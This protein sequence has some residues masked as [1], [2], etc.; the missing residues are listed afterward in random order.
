MSSNLHNE[1]EI[2]MD[3]HDVII[4]GA[5]FTGLT[6]GLALARAGCRVMILEKDSTPGGLAG[7][8]EFRNGVRAEKFYHYWYNNDAY[9]HALV[10]E[11]GME[12]HLVTMPSRTGMFYGGQF[13]QLTTPLDLLR[14]S[15][16]SFVDRLRLGLLVFKARRVKEWKSIEHLS[17]REWLKPLCGPEVYKVVWEPLIRSKFSIYADEIGAAWFWK[18][19]VLRGGTRDKKGGE[20]L[21]YFKGGFGRLADALADEIQKAGGAIHY[22]CP[23]TGVRVDNE[24][25]KVVTTPYG[26]V[27]GRQFL[28]TTSFPVIAGIFDGK[29]DEKWLR[30]LRRVRYLGNICLVLQLDRKLSNIFWLNVNDPDFPFVGVIEHTNFDGP[31][32]YAGSHIVY[33]SR[34]LSTQDP[35]WT[36]S[37]DAYLDLAFKHLERMYPGIDRSWIRDYKV[38]RADYAQPVTERNYSGYVPGRRTPYDNAWISTMA[39]VYPEDR[40]TNYSIREGYAVADIIAKDLNRQEL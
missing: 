30:Q 25:V 29:A 31:E 37:D 9:V 13:W 11:V 35:I 39:H 33:L 4:A 16:L 5:G 6:A 19:L 15:P 27:M 32:N 3:Q 21:A 24:Q 2:M 18:K 14:F 1:R 17:I 10:K 40:G 20:Q 26:A 38:W 28:F 8:F 36:C 22:D 34:Y 23:I 12:E 7:S